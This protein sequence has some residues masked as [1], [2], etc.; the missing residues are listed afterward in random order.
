MRDYRVRPE[1]REEN[2]WSRLQEA[3]MD[4]CERSSSKT[5]RNY[6]RKKV[7]ERVVAPKVAKATK[8][9]INTAEELKE[10]EREIRLSA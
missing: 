6:P 2:L 1:S 3:L 4:D 5:S 8:L 7:R 10:K 9:Q